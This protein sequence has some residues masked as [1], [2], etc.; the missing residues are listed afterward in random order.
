[1]Y[2][3]TD[4]LNEFFKK[5]EFPKGSVRITEYYKVPPKCPNCNHQLPMYLG[6]GNYEPA[7]AWEYVGAV[8][9]KAES[10]DDSWEIILGYDEINLVE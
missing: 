10:W 9:K 5:Q 1:M 2:D 6:F 8:I 7:R 4:E 3:M